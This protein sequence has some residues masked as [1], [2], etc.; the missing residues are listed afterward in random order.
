[1]KLFIFATFLERRRPAGDP[2]GR[3]PRKQPGNSG[4]SA[5]GDDNGGT[6]S[7][8]GGGGGGGGGGRRTNNSAALVTKEMRG[9][10]AVRLMREFLAATLRPLTYFTIEM[11][12]DS[13]EATLQPFQLLSLE[14]KNILVE[15]WDTVATAAEHASLDL[16]TGLFNVTVQS[17]TVSLPDCTHEVRPDAQR[18][19]CFVVEDPSTVDVLTLMGMLTNDSI[20]NRGKIR[21]WEAATSTLESCVGFCSPH[22]LLSN[23]PMLSPGVPTLCVLDELKK[24]GYKGVEQCVWHIPG[25]TIKKFDVRNAAS[26]KFYFQCV[27]HQKA[28]LKTA[29]AFH[30]EGHQ[31]FYR[32]LLKDPAGAVQRLSA[33]ECKRKM[34]SLEAGP[35]DMYHGLTEAQDVHTEEDAI[36]IDAGE[37]DAAPPPVPSKSRKR[38]L[39]HP[40]PIQGPS[41]STSRIGGEDSPVRSDAEIEADTGI[42]PSE[43]QEHF[44]R[45]CVS[46][47]T[48]QPRPPWL[49]LTILGVPLVYEP[50]KPGHYEARIRVTCP[51]HENC[52]KSRSLSLG[53]ASFGRQAAVGFIGA[54]LNRPDEHGILRWNAR[55]SDVRSFLGTINAADSNE[56][57]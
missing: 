17:Y 38:A 51:V 21:V 26:K 16:T 10:Q 15:T 13:G 49:P 45:G 55:A 24:M 22:E 46:V 39:N 19:D 20:D 35:E 12:G 56:T 57:A 7:G 18:M 31:T 11:E 1:M 37:A 14:K 30:S 53:Q 28:L 33:A 4:S 32:W 42:A 48:P 36:E 29:K 47:S 41:T 23:A 40:G 9:S 52:S 6:G 54:W 3:D 43:P 44:S 25:R 50:K 2:D 5:P 8:N 27:L 34:R